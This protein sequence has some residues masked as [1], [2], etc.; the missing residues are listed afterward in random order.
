[1]IDARD[2]STQEEL[3]EAMKREYKAQIL[4][5]MT[6]RIQILNS[7]ISII[8]SLTNDL[9]VYDIANRKRIEK[10]Y[11]EVD[12]IEELAK[13]IARTASSI[14]NTCRL[15]PGDDI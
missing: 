13:S 10:F 8:K 3:E 15:I 12:R 4:E 9:F 6:T 14:K 11:W 5:I 7:D 1:M 2:Y